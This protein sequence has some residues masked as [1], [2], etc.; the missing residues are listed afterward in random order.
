MGLH[1]LTERFFFL[2]GGGGRILGL[3][4][5]WLFGVVRV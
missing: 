1:E 5:C 2:Q 4:F 3:W